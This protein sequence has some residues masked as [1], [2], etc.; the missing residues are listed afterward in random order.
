M[1]HENLI[2]RI[3]PILHLDEE[4]IPRMNKWLH[5]VTLG[6]SDEVLI[7]LRLIDEFLVNF[8]FLSRILS[9]DTLPCMST[10]CVSEKW[11]HELISLIKFFE[12][13]IASKWRTSYV[14]AAN[15]LVDLVLHFLWMIETDGLTYVH[16]GG[17]VFL[18]IEKEIEDIALFGI[19]R[20]HRNSL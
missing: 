10:L 20:F 4:E 1:D 3:V 13:L 11:Y 7:D 14:T 6:S 15:K 5:R 8:K 17:G 9:E 16:E 18:I 2:L 12:D 19:E